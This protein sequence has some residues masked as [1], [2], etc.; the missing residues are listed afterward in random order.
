[1]IFHRIA[2]APL[3]GICTLRLMRKLLLAAAAVALT[4]GLGVRA[5]IDLKNF[6]L[7]VKPQDDFYRYANGTWLKN[8]PIPADQSR[9]GSFNE[10]NE[11]NQANLRA[12]CDRVAAKPDAAT[13]VEKMVGDFYASGMDEAAVN[14][15]G[16][17]PLQT[18]FDR[19]A[20][21][22]SSADVLKAIAHLQSF[23]IS[24][25]FRFGSQPD[26]KQSDREMAS[27][28]QGGLG[29]PERGYYFN[30]D[31]KSQKIRQQYVAHMINLLVLL[32][33][34]RESATVSASAVLALETKLALNSLARV[35]LRDPY[36]SYH[37][38]KLSEAAAKTPG[39]DFKLFFA[40]RGAPAFEDV[41]LAHP[42]FF[43]GFEAALTTVPVADW[44]A[45]LRWHLVRYAAPYLSEPFDQEQ[46]AF[47]GAILTG[48]TEQKPRWK[49]VVGVIDGSIGEALGQLYVAD[50][51]PPEAKARMAKLVDDL[52]AS[53]HDR[54]NALDW[55]DAPTRTKAQAKLAAFGVKIGYPDTWRDYSSVKITRDD[56]AGNVMRADA[57][58]V[59]RRLARIGQAV[60]RTEWGMTP[61][62]V[63]AYYR[64]TNNEIVFPAGI[65]QPPFFDFKAD[66]A[67]NYGGIGA[68]IG[69]E[70]TH[71]FDDS[72]SKYDATGNLNNWW[73]DDSAKNFKARTTAIVKQ[74]SGYS[75]LE[76]VHLNG[77]LTQGENVADLGGLKVA[78]Y[79]LQKALADKPRDPINGF[80]PE[81]RFFLNW[82]TIWR[83]NAREAVTRLL[84]NTDPHSPG[85]FRANGP[86]SN[87][88]EFAKA[89]S[90]P[91]SAPMRRPVETR[92]TIW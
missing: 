36:R 8:N 77:E 44:Q 91:E 85:E 10:L 63:N 65:L 92:V 31:E 60:D 16:V 87:L 3:G 26:L 40:E 56:Y 49:R 20:A 30:D 14:A 11:R 89:F 22:K 15:A 34:P 52:R 29:L 61:P 35:Q 82:A 47:N 81:Q 71:G 43:K 79:A 46:F 90:V 57:F 12:I 58:E 78:Y 1:V 66:D 33:E 6:D 37:K 69:H 24:C 51:F 59:S 17:K 74:F 41:N 23:G 68:V 86:L 53:L 83:T 9:W 67:V 45:Y 39:I 70:M 32:G 18:E 76:G 2:L 5:E 80:T 38:M 28:G 84:A 54:L 50:Y 7:T 73:S 42:E 72:G 13:A 62:T 27:L 75:P 55:M 64:P 88:D 48:T 19:I 25:G 21:I 4:L